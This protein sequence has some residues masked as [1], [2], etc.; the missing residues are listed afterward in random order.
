[1]QAIRAGVAVFGA[2]GWVNTIDALANGDVTKWKEVMSLSW[3]Y[4]ITKLELDMT[5][6]AYMKRLHEIQMK[7]NERSK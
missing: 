3:A 4:A 2:F 1:M 6:N 7:D 5:K